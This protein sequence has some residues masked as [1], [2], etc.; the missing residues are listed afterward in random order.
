MLPVNK[1]HL[2]QLEA[3]A[4]HELRRGNRKAA[5]VALQALGRAAPERGE[6][7]F[8]IGRLYAAAGDVE[9]AEQAL[10]IAA[11]KAPG[12]RRVWEAWARA[13]VR[14]DDPKKTRKARVALTKSPFPK[15]V[16]KAL[17]AAIDGSVARSSG[18]STGG[19]ARSDISALQR[20]IETGRSGEAADRAGEILAAAPGSAV[21]HLLHAVALTATGDLTGA[22][23][24]IDGALKVDPTYPEALAQRGRLLLALGRSR[25]ALVA[26][27][28]AYEQ[29]PASPL[30][31][32]NLALAHLDLAH[33]D[34]AR[35]YID[36]LLKRDPD[37]R[38]GLIARASWSQHNGNPQ[39][40]LADLEHAE[41][42]GAGADSEFWLIRQRCLVSLMRLPEAQKA[43]DEAA[44]FPGN[45]ANVAL[46]RANMLAGAG[47]F[48]AARAVL[49]DGIKAD[50]TAG[51]LYRALVGLQKFAPGDPLIEQMQKVYEGGDIRAVARADLGFSLFK[52]LDDSGGS[53]Q[54]F[55][56]LAEA[57]AILA[58]RFP[59]D[60][61]RAKAQYARLRRFFASE[62]PAAPARGGAAQGPRPIFVTGLPRSGTT[63]VEQILAAHPEVTPLG[64][65]GILSPLYYDAI[66]AKERF[67]DVSAQDLEKVAQS[68]RAQ[69]AARAPGAGVITDKSLGTLDLSGLVWAAFPDA[70]LV[71]LDRD[72]R[73]TLYS[74]YRN[75]FA[76]GTHLYANDQEHLVAIAREA[77]EMAAFWR[78]RGGSRWFQISYEA[79]VRDPEPEIRRLLDH[80][81]LD[82]DPACLSFHTAKRQVNTL[83]VHQVRQPISTS[84]LKGW[85][86]Y[87]DGLRPMLDGLAKL[88][89]D[90]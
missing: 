58:E 21:V 7:D 6:V 50:P 86:R 82:W 45:R 87:E 26:L 63:L 59:F 36:R 18:R 31:L 1:A 57:N 53:D 55:R 5:L 51:G 39:A 62:P 90:G 88:E 70:R 34:K 43:L 10:A 28:A 19:V 60:P 30:V 79:L 3:Q 73:E 77:R 56:Y 38:A 65:A 89:A 33:S 69:A 46:A 52:A 80:C 25:E 17:K 8:Q 64:E 47:D 24:A 11:T 20:L 9:K 35:H 84:S 67:C 78:E 49:L 16:R 40:A 81:G 76:I 13:L 44:K 12:E 42:Q 71:V 85:K 75:R 22:M 54:A 41:R 61:D 4:A 27:Y 68:Y 14:L 74:M 37:N 23:S 29:I 2:N 32:G 72:P 48:D 15:P 83:S 66:A